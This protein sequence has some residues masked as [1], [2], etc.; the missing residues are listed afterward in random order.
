MLGRELHK[1]LLVKGLRFSERICVV[2]HYLLGNSF[3]YQRGWIYFTLNHW[4]AIR[5]YTNAYRTLKK[6][7]TCHSS[8]LCSSA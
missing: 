4:K 5:I 8:K 3:M 6:P 2:S 1:L 7:S